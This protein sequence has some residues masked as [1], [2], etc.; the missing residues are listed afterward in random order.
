MKPEEYINR[1]V[2][3]PYILV[4]E[5]RLVKEKYKS[6][7]GRLGRKKPGV[8]AAVRILTASRKKISSLNSKLRNI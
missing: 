6:K 3:A 4:N 2:L 8:Y 7:G 5:I 1:P